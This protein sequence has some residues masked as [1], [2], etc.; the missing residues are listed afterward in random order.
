MI[1]AHITSLFYNIHA[2][3]SELLTYPIST[4]ALIAAIWHECICID[5]LGLT[6]ALFV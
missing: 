6:Y 4:C 3:K 1:Y 2:G 5:V